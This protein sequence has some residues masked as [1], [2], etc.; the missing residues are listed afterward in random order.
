MRA[1]ATGV[2]A[3]ARI[4]EQDRRSHQS[5]IRVAFERVYEWLEP[6]LLYLDIR[7]Q[8]RDI[9]AVRLANTSVDAGTEAIVAAALYESH[10]RISASD[11]V[12]G[13]VRRHVIDYDD[14]CPRRVRPERTQAGI[15]LV[16]II[17]GDDDDGYGRRAL[18]Y[19]VHLV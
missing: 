9:R 18:L 5:N 14:L 17:V 8:H 6:I 10:R 19:R 3:T 12:G 2:N 13:A 15:D 7:I 1:I 16:A 4:G 11:I